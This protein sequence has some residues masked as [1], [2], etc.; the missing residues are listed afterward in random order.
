MDSIA[1]KGLGNPDHVGEDPDPQEEII[2]R[3]EPS[4]LSV[5]AF[6]NHEAP[7]R[8]HTWASVNM[9]VCLNPLYVPT[10]ILPARIQDRLSLM[11]RRGCADLQTVRIDVAAARVNVP[12]AREAFQ[13]LFDAPQVGRSQQVILVEENHEIATGETSAA[14]PRISKSGA[15]VVSNIPHLAAPAR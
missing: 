12:C 6:L 14:I 11:R 7:R 15:G 13:R 4:F 3:D 2:V 8:D 1:C 5:G 10:G 9:L